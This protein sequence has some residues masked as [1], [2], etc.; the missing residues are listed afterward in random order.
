MYLKILKN[1]QQNRILINKL[2]LFYYHVL[3]DFKTVIVDIVSKKW[4]IN[5]E[6]RNTSLQK[7]VA[8]N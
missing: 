7:E 4:Y 5:S 6:I 3:L 8:L 1:I 2:I